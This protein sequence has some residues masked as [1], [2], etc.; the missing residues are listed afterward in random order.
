MSDTQTKMK[1][2]IDYRLREADRKGDDGNEVDSREL[3]WNYISYA[4][5]TK[6]KNG[7]EGQLRRLWG[8]IQRKIDEAIEKKE[9][10]VALEKAEVDFIKKAVEECNYLP[11]MSLYIS[12]LEDEIE[13][14]AKLEIEN[15]K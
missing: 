3:T 1:L 7:I 15:K 11:Q 10:E 4:V 13:R 12:P 5:N 14:L 6:Y 9:D 8:R 2:N